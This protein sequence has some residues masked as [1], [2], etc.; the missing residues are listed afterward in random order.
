MV[1]IVVTRAKNEHGFFYNFIDYY[2]NLGFDYI[3]IFV[4]K[5][6]K[7]NIENDR[8][9][10]IK[11]KLLGDKI[12]KNIPNVLKDLKINIKWVLHVDIDE[13]LFLNNMNIKEYIERYSKNNI[14]QFIFRWGMIENFCSIETE[15]N[16]QNIVNK[17]NI[18]SNKSYKSMYNLNNVIKCDN[19]HFVIVDNDT[20]I[21]DHKINELNYQCNYYSYNNSILIHFHTRCLENTFIKALTF[22]LNDKKIKPS[23]LNN[24]YSCDELKDN[25]TKLQLPFAHSKGK[26]L[27]KNKIVPIIFQT[28]TIVNKEIINNM[29][30]KVCNKY[31][32]NINII[33]NY[34]N[35]LENNYYQHFLN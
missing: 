31:N 5:N 9:L 23:L 35:E 15:N 19:P 18:Y 20:Y 26:I 25:M 17:C 27:N 30:I 1:N 11:H 34:I 7:Y 14:G 3:I 12:C 16:F 33:K 10:L 21:N 2:L 22:N 6:Q 13:Y 4:E 32:I 29:L 24:N 28:N 8:I